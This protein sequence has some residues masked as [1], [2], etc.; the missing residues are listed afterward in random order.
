MDEIDEV[1][2]YSKT[3]KLLYVE[4]NEDSR[5]ATQLVFEEFFSQI[6]IGVDGQDGYE[7]FQTNDVDIIITD[8]NMPRLDGLQMIDKI[9]QIDKDIPILVL[10]AYNESGY[11]ME[12]IKIGVEGYLLKPIDLNQ[13]LSALKGITGK[14]KLQI[15]AQ[16]NL[17]LLTQYQEITDNSSIVSKTNLDGKI[18]FVNDTFVAFSG[19]SREELIGQNYLLIRYPQNDTNFYDEIWDTVKNKKQI[20]QGT[21]RNISKSGKVYYSR[22]T[23]KPILDISNE[24][25]EYITLEKDI[26]NIM[27]PQKLLEDM[28]ISQEIPMLILVKMVDYDTL[29]KFYGQH[30][31]AEI[32][33]KFSVFLFDMMKTNFLFDNVFVL[34]EGRFAFS[35]DKKLCTQKLEDIEKVIQETISKINNKSFMIEDTVYDISIMISFSYNNN[36]LDNV[37]LGLQELENSKQDYIYANNLASIEYE[38]AQKNMQTLQLV[39]TAI[40]HNKIISYFQPIIDNKTQKIVKYESLVR[41]VDENDKVLA[42]FFFLDVAKRGKFYSQITKIV[43]QN[44]FEALKKTDKFISMNLSAL[45]IEKESI[46]NFIFEILEKNKENASRVVFE[47]LEDENIKDMNAVKKFITRAKQYG[48]K[49][50]IDDFGAGYSNFERLLDYQPDIL[51]IDASLIKNILDDDYSLAVVKTLVTFAKSQKIEIIA[52][53]VE[54]KEIYELLKD[55]EIEYSQGY[56]FGKPEPLDADL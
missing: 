11:F 15:Q 51:K 35:Q 1:L 28:I 36:V 56:Y 10:S 37:L 45:D 6:I 3:L 32:E 50:A 26:T 30:K 40:N 22:T 55:L 2:Q 43:L 39:N 47:L 16:Q 42:P 25:I 38:K 5:E 24:I 29:H 14:I 4:D 52:E 19:Y 48:V 46:S 54:S 27:R 7:K 23:I 41:L 12:S 49:I 53:Y 18:T 8:I 31:I 44:S 17:S 33:E 9:R 20:W 21:I 13:F 34:G